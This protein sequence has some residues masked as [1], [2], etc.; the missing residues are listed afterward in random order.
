MLS[1]QVLPGDIAP[2]QQ[3]LNDSQSVINASGQ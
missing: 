2:I 1:G 3:T